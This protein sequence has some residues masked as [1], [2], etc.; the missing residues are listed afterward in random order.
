VSLSSLSNTEL[1]AKASD[2]RN[3]AETARTMDVRDA[4][5]R[6]AMRYE[7]F[8]LAREMEVRGTDAGDDTWRL[9]PARRRGGS[10][11]FTD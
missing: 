10:S 1:R 9:P 4:L 8:V 5:L 11:A 3:M 6:L 7:R 2:L